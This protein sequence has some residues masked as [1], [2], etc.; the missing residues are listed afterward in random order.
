MRDG[1]EDLFDAVVKEGCK[2][3]IRPLEST[4]QSPRH[5]RPVTRALGLEQPE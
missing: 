4:A 3:K 5:A 2:Q 1:R